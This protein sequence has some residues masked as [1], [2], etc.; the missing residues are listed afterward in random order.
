MLRAVPENRD[1][2]TSPETRG[3]SPEEMKIARE[4]QA[5]LLCPKSLRMDRLRYCG[6]SLPAGEIGGDYFDFLDAGPGR[7]GLAL[8]DISGKGVS[9]AL[10]MAGL[11]ASLRS[12]YAETADD[13]GRLLR[14]VNR[15]FCESTAAQHYAS[16]FL[17]DY[18]D[19]TGRLRYANCGHLPPLLL[20][21]D[22][23]VCRLTPTA[24][25]LG[26]FE[27]WECAVSEVRLEPG[28]TLLMFTDGATEARNDRG[29]EYG[30][31]RLL[32][33]LSR[34]RH[35]PVS[36]L[37]WELQWAIRSFSGSRRHDDLTLVAA[38]FGDCR[39]NGPKRV[40]PFRTGA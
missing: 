18:D 10:M 32:E 13:L 37:V 1:L 6:R 16:L 9:A 35:L 38:R 23:T 12:L 26:M 28:D 36:P 31:A 40:M 20:H 24:T 22:S 3:P 27:E 33:A 4:V 39:P 19:A 5:R 14:S 25:V 17:A 15:L 21:A 29:D 11:Q 30:E 8:G 34:R 7:L 2:T